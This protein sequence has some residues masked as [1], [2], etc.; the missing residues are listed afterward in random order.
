MLPLLEERCRKLAISKLGTETIWSAY[1]WCITNPDDELRDACHNYFR[2]GGT[3]AASALKSPAFLHIPQIVLADMLRIN[4]VNN[5]GLRSHILIAE[6]GL[7]R[8]CND[9]AE[10]QCVQQDIKPS[11][12]NKRKVLGE[13]LSS[14]QFGMMLIEDIIGT[15]T[16]T[17]ILNANERCEIL[18]NAVNVPGSKLGE[19]LMK[20]NKFL[21]SVKPGENAVVVLEYSALWKCTLPMSCIKIEVRNKLMLSAVW[22]KGY[23]H[24][25]YEVSNHEIFVLETEK[26]SA[27]STT[28]CVQHGTTGEGKPQLLYV[29]IE[30]V[31]LLAGSKYEI[32]ATALQYSHM[33]TNSYELSKNRFSYPV[34]LPE[35]VN[36]AVTETDHN[37]HIVGLSVHLV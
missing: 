34:K 23:A 9:W 6:I 21:L 22:L 16:P 27:H 33:Y 31:V 29:E 10:A 15:V 19:K 36:F 37:V 3:A 24:S 11:G 30:P 32:R 28:P 25:D 20:N 12:K 8:G 1:T 18:E 17:G 13:C 2:N 7:F 26:K 35:E 5:Y 4:S 14:I